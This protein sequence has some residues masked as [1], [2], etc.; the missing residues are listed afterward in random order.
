[1]YAAAEKALSWTKTYDTTATIA[2]GNR[3]AAHCEVRGPRPGINATA[4][5]LALSAL[6]LACEPA[7][8]LPSGGGVFSPAELLS[9]TRAFDILA[10]EAVE[11]DVSI[12]AAVGRPDVA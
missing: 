12:S 8:R 3:V 1:M 11:A 4:T 2:G 6:C 7:E 5:C 9:H 10:R